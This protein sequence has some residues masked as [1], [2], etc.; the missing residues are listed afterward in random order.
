M[1]L[2]ELKSTIS[3]LV[4]ETFDIMFEQINPPVKVVV[5]TMGGTKILMYKDGNEEHGSDAFVSTTTPFKSLVGSRNTNPSRLIKSD[6]DAV[7]ILNL[8]DDVDIDRLIDKNSI[9]TTNIPVQILNK[10][11]TSMASSNLSESNKKQL[12]KLIKKIIEEEFKG[13]PN[14]GAEVE[15]DELTAHLSEDSV[16]D[17]IKDLEALLANP[18]PSRAKDYGSIDNYK[19]MLGKK[20]NALKKKSANEAVIN[21]AKTIV[22]KKKTSCR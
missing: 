9:I 16:A 1:N 6:R 11:S 5:S 12:I 19:K 18:D 2:K 14:D 4:N 10:H 15:S 7:E 3:E 8:L 17:D 13:D 22:A 21:K 20:I